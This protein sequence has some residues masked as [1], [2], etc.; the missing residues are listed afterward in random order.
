MLAGERLLQGLGDM[1]E[2]RFEA[3]MTALADF[4]NCKYLFIDSCFAI[5]F[6]NVCTRCFNIYS[7]NE[8]LP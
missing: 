2:E 4:L 1:I 6:C 7:P 8:V 3:H 5:N